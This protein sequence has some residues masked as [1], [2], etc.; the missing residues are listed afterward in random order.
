M[1]D[2]VVNMRLCE[3]TFTLKIFKVLPKENKILSLGVKI[4]LATVLKVCNSL[5]RDSNT[6]VFLYIFQ[7]FWGELFLRKNS[8]G[9][10]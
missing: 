9:H 5:K 4:S 8:N 7:K 10:F 1:F 2:L 6:G 3:H